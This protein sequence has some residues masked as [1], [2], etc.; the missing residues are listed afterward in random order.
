MYNAL[1][2]R[3]DSPYLYGVSCQKS[4]RTWNHFK[5]KATRLQVTTRCRPTREVRSKRFRI[6]ISSEYTT[7]MF[8]FLRRSINRVFSPLGISNWIPRGLASDYLISTRPCLLE[9]ARRVSRKANVSICTLRAVVGYGSAKL[10]RWCI[11][12]LCNC[13]FICRFHLFHLLS[14]VNCR[15]LNWML[16]M[17]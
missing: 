8:C 10:F 7:S 12:I 9:F 6:G 14:V 2:I 1:R 13:T 16:S 17:L 3:L 5:K 15:L 11:I 4:F